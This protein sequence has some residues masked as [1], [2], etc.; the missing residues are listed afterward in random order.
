M[1]FSSLTY[2]FTSFS[3]FISRSIDHVIRQGERAKR[4][5]KVRWRSSSR[6][7]CFL[8]LML[9]L[10]SYFFFSPSKSL[11]LM[12]TMLGR[13]PCNKGRGEMVLSSFFRFFFLISPL[14]LFFCLLRFLWEVGWCKNKCSYLHTETLSPFP[15]LPAMSKWSEWPSPMFDH[16]T[17]IK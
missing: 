13:S 1:F 12:S 4:R 14:Y 17:Y 8:Q 10:L 2:F 3:I 9:F 7:F 11:F 15:H 5:K 6:F 16:L